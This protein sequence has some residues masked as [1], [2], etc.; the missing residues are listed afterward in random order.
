MGYNVIKQLIEMITKVKEIYPGENL[1][2]HIDLYQADNK[3]PL[4]TS[5]I[6][7]GKFTYT[8]YGK[9]VLS[10]DMPNALVVLSENRITV[11]MPESL[12]RKLN[13]G[14]LRMSV[15]LNIEDDSYEG[16]S[17]IK[18]NEF[19]ICDVVP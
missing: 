9:T 17:N 7:S 3:T 1:K 18:A 14:L 6:Q 2:V 16:G 4:S 15:R 5:L 11:E 10:L 12:S 19:L 8:Q 13:R